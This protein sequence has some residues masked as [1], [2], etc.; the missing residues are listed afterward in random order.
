MQTGS[1]SHILVVE[2]DVQTRE[3]LCE[4][5]ID[6]G[7]LPLAVS[8]G[9]EALEHL[10]GHEW[11]FQLRAPRTKSSVD[12]SGQ[13]SLTCVSPLAVVRHRTSAGDKGPGFALEDSLVVMPARGCSSRSQDP[14]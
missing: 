3:A 8:D 14:P 9:V 1:D 12:L 5:L 11:C 13:L 4:S 7:Y 6:A 2:D 10:P